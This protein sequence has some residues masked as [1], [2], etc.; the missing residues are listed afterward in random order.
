MLYNFVMKRI[1]FAFFVISFAVNNVYAANVY[2]MSTP[3]EGQSLA[4]DFLQKD[5][6][7]KVYSIAAKQN[8]LCTDFKIS[9]T[10]LLH[11]P[12]DAEKKDGKYVKG[13]WKELW[14]VNY[15]GE[16]IQIPVT[17]VIKNKKT[18]FEVENV[19]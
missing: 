14:T 7:K 13:Y 12:Y 10:Q 18:Y 1:F 8:S 6:L 3:L 5:V 4:S 19:N 17:F 15:C 2:D 9:D 16:N 11:F